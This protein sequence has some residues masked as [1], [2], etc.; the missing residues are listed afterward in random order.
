M[1]M[2]EIIIIIIITRSWLLLKYVPNPF[3]DLIPSLF[4]LGFRVTGCSV[5][6]G[7]PLPL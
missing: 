1:I 4:P 5:P 2:L 7:F 3:Q 6:G